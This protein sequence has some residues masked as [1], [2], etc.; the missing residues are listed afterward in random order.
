MANTLKLAIGLIA[1]AS[2]NTIGDISEHFLSSQSSLQ[3]QQVNKD[4]QYMIAG[5][6]NQF[7]LKALQNELKN[8][9]GYI[10]AP[11]N[12][13]SQNLDFHFL[14]YQKYI[15]P[16]CGDS[17]PDSYG[18]LYDNEL[19]KCTYIFDKV[20][21]EGTSVQNAE[22]STHWTGYTLTLQSHEQKCG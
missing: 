21:F 20:D 6:S 9:D 17:M 1:S 11:Q 14:L 15:D 7:D 12:T 5:S 19:Q 4:E 13:Q 2:A 22:N 3:L 8:D 16:L 18:F 10:V